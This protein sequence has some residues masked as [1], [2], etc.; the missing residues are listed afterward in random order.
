M[1]SIVTVVLLLYALIYD[2]GRAFW[3]GHIVPYT[4]KIQVRSVYNLDR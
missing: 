3:G 1:C 4:A 2:G